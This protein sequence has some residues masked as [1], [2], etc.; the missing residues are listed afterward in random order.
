MTDPVRIISKQRTLKVLRFLMLNVMARFTT[1]GHNHSNDA[2]S[3][4]HSVT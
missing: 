3:T 2:K 4:F 1:S